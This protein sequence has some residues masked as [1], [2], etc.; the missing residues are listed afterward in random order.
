M[1]DGRRDGKRC[2]DYGGNIELV[3]TSVTLLNSS[4]NVLQLILFLIIIVALDVYLVR[5]AVAIL[6]LFCF[7]LDGP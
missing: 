1:D 4:R 2:V 5:S 6:W 7:I 3:Y